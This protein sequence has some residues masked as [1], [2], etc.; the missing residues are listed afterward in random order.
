M[1][2][3]KI[4]KNRRKLQPSKYIIQEKLRSEEEYRDLGSHDTKK[5][6]IQELKK[7]VEKLGG[8]VDYDHNVRLVRQERTIIMSP[9][10]L[11]DM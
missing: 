3:A 2:L 11:S 6:A 7:A 5:E 4:L 1:S 10:N 9:I 8:R